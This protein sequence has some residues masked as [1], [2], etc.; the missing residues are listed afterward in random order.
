MDASLNLCY[1][2][3]DFN[4]IR[5]ILVLGKMLG[6]E[7]ETFIVTQDLDKG[8]TIKAESVKEGA[9]FSLTIDG[10]LV[11]TCG[12]YMS[13]MVTAF[14]ACWVLGLRYPK[15]VNRLFSFVQRFILLL[16]D[17]T[18][19]KLSPCVIK[20]ANQLQLPNYV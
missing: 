8:M 18:Y 7:V 10:V 6:E 4:P 1:C 3:T 17:P 13:S 9:R 16:K 20:V 5:A 14:A 11:C 12:D 19:K 15:C 2:F